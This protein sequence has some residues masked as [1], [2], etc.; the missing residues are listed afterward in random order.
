MEVPQTSRQRL[1]KLAGYY[2]LRGPVDLDAVVLRWQ[3]SGDKVYDDSMPV[4]VS[5]RQ[6][7]G[8]REYTW[9]REKSR[10]GFARLRGKNEYLPGPE[11]WDA[12]KVDLRLRGWDP[13]EPLIFTIG[14]KGGMKV[15]EGNHRLALAKELGMRTV[16][17]WFQFYTDR[18]R[19][20]PQES[21][22][23]VVDNPKAVAEAV[24]KA[25]SR[26][27]TPEEEARLDKLMGLLG[28]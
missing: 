15:G 17:V 6:L 14:R 12:L 3:E 21:E 7:W 11:K 1:L 28:F 13:S 23:M 22:P 25:P 8:H 16:P 26:K 27:R 20:S 4:P 5:L 19:K 2:Q 18:V 24:V 9:T 10:G